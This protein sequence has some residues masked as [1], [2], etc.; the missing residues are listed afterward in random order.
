VTNDTAA[1]GAG[2]PFELLGDHVIKQVAV[3][4]AAHCPAPGSRRVMGPWAAKAIV[5]GLVSRL[6]TPAR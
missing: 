5:K 3:R 1:R 6:V 2:D 4:A